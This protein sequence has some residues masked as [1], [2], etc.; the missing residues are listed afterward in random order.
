MKK[1][2]N[3]LSGLI[4]MT[5]LSCGGGGDDSNSGF[6]NNNN[7]DPVIP[8][9]KASVLSKPANNSE[10]LEVD[11]VNFEWNSSDNTDSYTINV[12]NSKCSRLPKSYT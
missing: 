8:S 9:P 4:I 10:C 3:I 12:K 6:D 1:I 7:S 5:A 11:A 2:L